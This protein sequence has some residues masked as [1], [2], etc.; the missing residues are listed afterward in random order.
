MEASSF[1]LESNCRACLQPADTLESIFASPADDKPLHF[2]EILSSLLTS[3]MEIQPRDGLS[4]V[5]CENCRVHAVNA[6]KFQ[7]MC[8]A[9][10][11]QAREMLEIR[12]S[13]IKVEDKKFEAI[14][15][16]VLMEDLKP[17]EEDFETETLDNYEEDDEDSNEDSDD[18]ENKKFGC[19]SC[20][21]QF[22]TEKKLEQHMKNEHGD[23]EESGESDEE[24]ARIFNCDLC[25]K[26]FKKPSLLSRH[27]K[28]HDPNKR[29]HGTR[30][31]IENQPAG[32]AGFPLC[33]LWTSLQVLGVADDASE[34]AQGQRR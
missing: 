15:G 10:D 27:L 23:D 3:E 2:A 30:G 19:D 6:Y 20:D 22:Q 28:T 9:N 13:S 4:Q 12:A 21:L 24:S 5:I 31:A 1:D 17:L 33:R 26:K 7:Q 14:D 11:K 29:P 32:T 8:R 16:D 34:V 18:S 25:P